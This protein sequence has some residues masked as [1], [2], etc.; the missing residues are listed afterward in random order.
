LDRVNQSPD[1]PSVSFLLFF[2]FL[3]LVCVFLFCLSLCCSYFCVF[4]WFFFRFPLLS[5]CSLSF[6]RLLMLLFPPPPCVVLSLA[7]IKPENV[8]NDLGSHV[9]PC[10]LEEKLGSL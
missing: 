5:L 4:V 1:L 6:F 7:F 8:D 2:L 9:R 10:V 3:S